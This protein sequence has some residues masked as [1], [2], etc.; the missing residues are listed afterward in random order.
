[1]GGQLVSIL[2]GHNQQV[3]SRAVGGKLDRAHPEHGLTGADQAGCANHV[4]PSRIE[5]DEPTRVKVAE[6][7][8][9]TF[10]KLSD[11][12]DIAAPGQPQADAGAIVESQGMP[13]Q[14]SGYE[15]ASHSYTVVA[16]SADSG[17][18]GCENHLVTGDMCAVS[19][20]APRPPNLLHA[21][22][23]PCL[24]FVG[25]IEPLSDGRIWHQLLR[26]EVLRARVGVVVVAVLA[27]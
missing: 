4:A 7:G 11:G 26:R 25:L 20:P 18:A 16:S 17:P 12:P 6:A 21:L 1:M 3:R 5:V 10:Q 19:H 22:A 23:E 24:R 27:G 9:L 14:G 15:A 2:P 13:E 8:R